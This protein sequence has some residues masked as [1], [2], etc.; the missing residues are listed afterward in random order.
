MVYFKKR[1]ASAALFCVTINKI[2]GFWGALM[3]NFCDL[4]THSSFSDGTRTPTQLVEEAQQLGLGAIALTDH[5]TIAGL[6][7]LLRA[8]L[9]SDLERIPGI[10]LSTEFKG[11]ELHIIG[12]Y[13][14]PQ[15]YEPLTSFL[16]E[17][18]A[19]KE[20]SNRLLAE[21]LNRAGYEIDYDALRAE[22]RG[23]INRAVIAAELLHKGYTT[24]IDKA[25]RGV[26]S[27]QNG[28][29]IPPKRISSLDAIRLLSKLGA[30]PVLA[31]PFLSL[32]EPQL[33][34]FLPQAKVCGLVALETHYVLNTAK[35]TAQSISIAREYDLLESGGSDYHGENKPNIQLGVGLGTLR[36][37]LFFVQKLHEAA[38]KNKECL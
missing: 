33:R 31:H 14:P 24:S 15:A 18:T 6:N 36:V 17:A 25:L 22:H 7:E 12:L 32:T 8:P 34:D 9:R 27:E 13:L 29:Y 30:I 11:R 19:R 28:F 5:N 20:E 23:N 4:H 2:F 10:E 16:D 3:R 1:A 21:K 35:V 37:P 26:L 38:L